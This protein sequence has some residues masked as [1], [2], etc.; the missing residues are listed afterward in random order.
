MSFF[1]CYSHST[2]LSSS[3]WGKCVNIYALGEQVQSAWI[4]SD[5]ATRKLT[6]TSVS[7]P[8]VA[9]AVALYLESNPNLTPAEI[10]NRLQADATPGIL[11]E[12]DPIEGTSFVDT[13]NLL[14]NVDD[15][16]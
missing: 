16:P 15:L 12:I 3:N 14:L 10:W 7:S 2:R 1:Y 13:P 11:N 8:I 6:G 9:G 4:K 5:A